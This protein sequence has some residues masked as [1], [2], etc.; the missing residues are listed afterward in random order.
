MVADGDGN[1]TKLAGGLDCAQKQLAEDLAVQVPVS[2]DPLRDYVRLDDLDLGQVLVRKCV[3]HGQEV[4][5]YIRDL[6]LALFECKLEQVHLDLGV[7]DL[8]RK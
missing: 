8:A 7:R 3:E 2:A 6:A 4:G 5:Y 1:F